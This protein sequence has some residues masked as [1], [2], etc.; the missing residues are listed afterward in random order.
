VAF[1]EMFVRFRIYD[2]LKLLEVD[3]FCREVVEG[4]TYGEGSDCVIYRL[5]LRKVIHKR[6]RERKGQQTN[7]SSC[8]I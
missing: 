7:L 4:L 8:L 1:L 2:E 3:H 5:Y 6:K